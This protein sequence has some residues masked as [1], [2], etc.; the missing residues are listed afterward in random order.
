MKKPLWFYSSLIFMF[1]LPFTLIGQRM[2]PDSLAAKLTRIQNAPGFSETDTTYINTLYEISFG[3][4]R[5]NR[6]SARNLAIRTISLSEKI[7][8]QKGIAYGNYALALT[9]LLDGKQREAIQLAKISEQKAEIL[10]LNKMV[11]RARNTKGIAYRELQQ[12]DSAFLNYY[13]GLKLAESMKSHRHMYAFHVNLGLLF[14]N[15]KNYKEALIHYK[16]A[17]P[18]VA[19]MSSKN[20]TLSHKLKI[21]EVYLLQNQTDSAFSY[22]EQA[23]YLIENQVGFAR[24][25]SDYWNQMGDFY[26]LKEKQELADEAYYRALSITDS[27][28]EPNRVTTYAGLAESAYRQNK[29]RSSLQFAQKALA[30]DQG[31]GLLNTSD[32]LYKLIALLYN[33]TGQKDSAQLYFEKYQNRYMKL[34][35]SIMSKQIAMLQTKENE[36]TRLA[37]AEGR[38]IEEAKSKKVLV[39]FWVAVCIAGLGLSIF[40]FRGYRHYRKEVFKLDRINQEKDQLFTILGHDLRSPLSTMQELILLYQEPT[41]EQYSL[42]NHLGS[43]QRRVF[44]SKETLNNMMHWVQEQV[45][46]AKPHKELIMMEDL[47]PKCIAAVYEIAE[48]KNLSISFTSDPRGMLIADP[49]H[50][51]IILNNLLINAI[52]FSSENRAIRLKWSESESVKRLSI[53]DEGVGFSEEQ[54]EQFHKKGK[55]NSRKGTSG[56]TGLGLGLNICQKLMHLNKGDIQIENTEQGTRVN[57]FFNN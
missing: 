6:D 16:D 19:A 40:F 32:E 35:K 46:D 48:K 25:H 52:K 1:L 26:L 49:I 15:N 18:S 30:I 12:V 11:L 43:L 39:W 55:L 34:Q 57:L 8:Y 5:E 54:L 37:R 38:A 29:I 28:N 33:K 50:L 20:F 24:E 42:D 14:L 21:A 44:Y 31:Q 10:D 51:E 23:R 22:L 2:D 3:L 53:E 56:E 7:N 36:K 4:G 17:E 27:L 47:I 45:Q 41:K 9:K 13:R